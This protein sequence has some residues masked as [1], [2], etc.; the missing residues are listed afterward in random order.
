M[1]SP[2]K[3]SSEAAVR[4]IRRRTRRKFSRKRRS[5]LSLKASEAIRPNSCDNGRVCCAPA[6][7]LDDAIA[8]LGRRKFKLRTA[9]VS[10]ALLRGVSQSPFEGSRRGVRDVAR[11]ISSW[12][13]ICSWIETKAGPGTR[14]L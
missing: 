7:K 11:S 8:F 12:N 6:A 5:A 9:L 14:V 1:T 13:S 2:K 10:I 3:Q 4:E